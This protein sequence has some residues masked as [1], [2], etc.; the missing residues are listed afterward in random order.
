[1]DAG[2]WVRERDS[3]CFKWPQNPWPKHPALKELGTWHMVNT[4]D[5]IYG[6]TARP[7]TQILGMPLEEVEALLAQVRNDIRNKRVHSYWPMIVVYGQKP[8]T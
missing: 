2:N 4:L 6:F 1:M 3:H 5:G 7:F 8:F